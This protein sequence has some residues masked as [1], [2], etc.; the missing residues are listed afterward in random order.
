MPRTRTAVPEIARV[1]AETAVPEQRW[2]RDGA[3]TSR[4]S[5]KA[6]SEVPQTG[7]T[8]DLGSFVA[9]LEI[10][11]KMSQRRMDTF[12]CPIR[13]SKWGSCYS[14]LM[15]RETQR[16]RFGCYSFSYQASETLTQLLL[17]CGGSR[18]PGR[19]KECAQ[20]RGSCKGSGSL[21]YPTA[22]PPPCHQSKH[23]RGRRSK[24]Q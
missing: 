11:K 13:V 21:P 24:W 4:G 6:G 12:F 9:G 10:C 2:H 19:G 5:G 3:A 16:D 23:V 15:A 22:L 14:L 17:G 20:H 8:Q 1:L 18:V 7:G